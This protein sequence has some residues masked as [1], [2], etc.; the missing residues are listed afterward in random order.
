MLALKE[1]DEAARLEAMMNLI[2]ANDLNFG[3][4]VMISSC[5]ATNQGTTDT[6]DPI[7]DASCMR[8][9]TDQ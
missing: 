5:Q 2:D 4:V 8:F 1:R 9:M 7:F 3:S 6:I